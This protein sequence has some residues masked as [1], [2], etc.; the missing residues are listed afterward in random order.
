MNDF[1]IGISVQIT[2]YISDDPQPG[3]VECQLVDVYGNEWLFQEKTAIVS[4]GD[5]DADTDYPQ[6]WFIACEIIKQWQDV[7]GREIVSVNTE[8]PWGIESLTGD[9]RFDVLRSQIIE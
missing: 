3:I 9:S 6:P 7:D 5:L 8:K 1:M 4:S 2:K